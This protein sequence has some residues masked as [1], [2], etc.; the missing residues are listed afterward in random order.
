MYPTAYQEYLVHF[1]G[2][3][4]YF[5]CH[6]ILEEYW[7]SLSDETRSHVW[8][9]LIQIAVGLYHHRR[10]N[11]AGAAKMLSSAVRI[12]TEHETEVAA[13]GLDPA[14]LKIALGTRVEQIAAGEPY[15]SLNLPIADEALHTLCQ[16][17][18]SEK[19]L[20]FGQPSNLAD[21][22]LIHKHTLRDRSDVI[23]ERQ[24][25]LDAKQQHRGTAG[26]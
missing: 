20:V 9:G 2:D 23:T 24:R 17:L 25:N 13:L 3:R 6:E 10:N 16:T 21:E 4:D 12:L 19:G 8:V 5:E 7:K 15:T 26:A 14:A 18:C 22:Y 11:T 1:H